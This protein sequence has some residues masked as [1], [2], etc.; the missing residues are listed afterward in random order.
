[1]IYLLKRYTKCF[2]LVTSTNPSIHVMFTTTIAC[3]SPKNKLK[4]TIP[5]YNYKLNSVNT[6]FLIF[7]WAFTESS[8]TFQDLYFLSKLYNSYDLLWTFELW[9]VQ[10]LIKKLKNSLKKYIKIKQQYFIHHNGMNSN[11]NTN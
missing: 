3:D 6:K 10:I 11:L 9:G 1:M 8:L 5:T 4:Y 2:V 7:V